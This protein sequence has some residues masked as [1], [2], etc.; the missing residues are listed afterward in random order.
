MKLLEERILRDGR[1]LPGNILKVD[2]FQNYLWRWERTI[3]NIL[4]DRVLTRYLH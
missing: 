2:K 3:M 1:I 4:K